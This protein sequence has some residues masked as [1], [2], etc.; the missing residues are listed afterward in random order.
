MV[1]V[2]PHLFGR[3]FKLD[4]PKL[5]ILAHVTEAKGAEGDARTEPVSFRSWDDRLSSTC[6]QLSTS[7]GEFI[8]QASSAR[9]NGALTEHLKKTLPTDQI[10]TGIHREPKAKDTERSSSNVTSKSRVS[11]VT[12]PKN[13]L[14]H[15][16]EGIATRKDVSDREHPRD[17]I[18][19]STLNQCF[20]TL[21]ED[22]IITCTLD[23]CASG[24]MINLPT[25]VIGDGF[26]G[27]V[28]YSSGKASD[29]HENEHAKIGDI[30]SHSNQIT[31][32][33]NPAED[34]S[35]VG[36]TIEAFARLVF[37]PLNVDPVMVTLHENIPEREKAMNR[38]KARI[39]SWSAS[40]QRQEAW[41]HNDGSAGLFTKSF[42][43]ACK[44][45]KATQSGTFTYKQLYHKANELVSRQREEATH[46][47]P[48]FVQL[49]SSLE[50][51]EQDTKDKLL[52]SLVVF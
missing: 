28:T 32:N 18:L 51:D 34:T 40:H 10:Q 52:E 22:C 17:M 19:D 47:R 42:T 24:R 49:W 29:L 21:P 45:L 15:Y 8:Q 4:D 13:E 38:V 9:E 20:S 26:R 36:G 6:L 48:Q 35:G 1:G 50:D 39:L 23:C 5:H 7:S 43:Q 12:V 44:E 27:K 16:N 46:P 31:N 33:S 30:S 41:D 37:Q 25:K 3:K 11:W 14:K 2:T